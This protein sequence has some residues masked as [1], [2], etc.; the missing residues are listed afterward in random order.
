MKKFIFLITMIVLLLGCKTN[1]KAMRVERSDRLEERT[2]QVE[3]RT[4]KS[5]QKK[6]DVRIET[7]EGFWERAKRTE[8]DTDGNVTAV[9]ETERGRDTKQTVNETQTDKAET[10]NDVTTTRDEKI[11][12]NQE[13]KDN[14][15]VK[16]DGRLIQ[17]VE[18]VWAMLGVAIVGLIYKT[19]IRR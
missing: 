7:L 18:W 12:D 14:Q 1:K 15:E 4:V 10:K 8:Y 5:E 11:V 19:F 13:L 2:E 3:D 17:G 9:E 6:L 16:N